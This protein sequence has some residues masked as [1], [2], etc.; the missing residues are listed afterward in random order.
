M[1][2]AQPLTLDQPDRPHRPNPTRRR[3]DPPTALRPPRTPDP[4]RPP[5]HTA[6]PRALA[7]ADGLHRSA[8]PHP[9]A[10]RRLT[11]TPTDPDSRA[12]GA[13]HA[14]PN[15]P[16]SAPKRPASAHQPTTA[17]RTA[18]TTPQPTPHR[19]TPTP[20][21]TN[22]GSS[23]S[24]RADPAMPQAPQGAARRPRSWAS[25]SAARAATRRA[26]VGSCAG[27]GRGG[28]SPALGVLHC[29]LA[30]PR[31]RGRSSRPPAQ[32]LL[33]RGD[34]VGVEGS[35]G[36]ILTAVAQRGEQFINL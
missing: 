30:A 29:L 7:L 33:K 25:F 1:P 8:H 2:R 34:V 20:P 23:L 16:A 4:Q 12:T 19:S 15:R 26:A 18:Q 28:G 35:P 24:T 14:S 36:Y 11:N 6:P 13:A 5:P 31:R 32:R 10:P 3:H 22:G 21:Q 9:S 27:C 17:I